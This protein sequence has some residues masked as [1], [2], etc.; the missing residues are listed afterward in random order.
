GKLLG[1][2]GWFYRVTGWRAAAI[3]GPCHWTIPPY[4]RYVVLGPSQPRRAAKALSKLLDGATVLVV[5]LNDFGGRI[6]GASHPV[7]EAL[8]LELL[9]QNPLGQSDQ[10]TPVGILRPCTAQLGQERAG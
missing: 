3:D 7:D 1:R 5:D 4:N 10:C 8:T 6:L 2:K 9:A